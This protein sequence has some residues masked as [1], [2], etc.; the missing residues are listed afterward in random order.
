M[1]STTDPPTEPPTEPP[2]GR[3][4]LRIREAARAV[5]I[6]PEDRVLLVRFEFPNTGRRWALPGGGLEAG[7]S[8]LDALR[9]ELHEELGLVDPLIGPHIWSRLHVIPFFDG[10]YDG[11]RERV[12]LVRT[13]SFDPQ[14]L[15]TPEQ[16]AAEYVFELRWWSLAQIKSD[17]GPFVPALLA[18]HLAS[19]LDHGPPDDPVDV[20]I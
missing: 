15:L 5:V 4:D 3:A 8:H 12:H 16:L 11:Q 1:A 9:R 19:L 2:H 17:E 10:R 20:G 14:P 13:R 18:I 6:D 7:E